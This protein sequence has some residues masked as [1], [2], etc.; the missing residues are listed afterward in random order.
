MSLTVA[1]AARSSHAT[2]T[3]FADDSQNSET[4]TLGSLSLGEKK[5]RRLVP[6]LV[7][8]LDVDLGDEKKERKTSLIKIRHCSVMMNISG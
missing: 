8:S 1:E 4:Q 6:L 3:F 5:R 7:M 2:S